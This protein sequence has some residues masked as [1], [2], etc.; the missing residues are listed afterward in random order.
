MRLNG[1]VEN[2][3][4]MSRLESGLIKVKPDWV[5]IN[6]LLYDVVNRLKEN[7]NGRVVS[8]ALTEDLPL[9]RVDYGLIQQVVHNLVQNAILYIPQYCIVTVSAECI[10]DCLMLVVEDNGLG[11]PSDEVDKVFEKFYRISGSETGGTGLG[12]SIVK[13]YVEAHNGSVKLENIEGGGARFTVLI[14]AETSYL[15]RLKND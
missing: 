14:P 6:E 5:D 15:N 11:F 13:G 10:K 2:L 4:S 1:Q 9:F 7:A 3:L 12:L 8:V